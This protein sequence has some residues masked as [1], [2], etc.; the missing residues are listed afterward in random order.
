[1]AVGLSL[2]FCGGATAPTTQS[3]AP[4]AN[5][6][7]VDQE[8]TRRISAIL[9]DCQKIKPGTTR[10]ELMHICTTEGGLST[11][12]S[13]T[14]VHRAC[15]YVKLDVQFTLSDGK[16]NVLEERPTDLI[17]HVSKPY[18]QWTISD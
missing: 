16:Q 11:A 1:L 14:F 9:L 4:A 13:R 7:D 10:A 3:T 12:K 18:L 6:K 5:V 8:L 2:L 17:S 15:P